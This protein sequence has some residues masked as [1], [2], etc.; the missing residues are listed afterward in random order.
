MDRMDCLKL[1]Y[2]EV[3]GPPNLEVPCP[4]MEEKEANGEYTYPE[5]L[6]GCD[7][8]KLRELLLASGL[9]RECTKG[10]RCLVRADLLR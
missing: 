5:K 7:C 2:Q 3:K 1:F 4:L 9:S 10:E 8:P 6:R